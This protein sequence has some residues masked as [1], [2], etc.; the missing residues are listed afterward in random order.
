MK[1]Q[2]GVLLL[3]VG[4]KSYAGWAVN[5]AA[6]LHFYSPGLTIDIIV[7]SV[8]DAAIAGM[9]RSLFSRVVHIRPSDMHDSD[10]VFAPGKAKLSLYGYSRFEQTIYIDADSCVCRD[11]SPLF[12][13]LAGSPVKSQAL[14]FVT[15]KDTDWG[16]H[17]MP[18]GEA[19]QTYWLMGEYIL[20]VINSSFI[21]FEKCAEAERFFGM[22]KDN[23]IEGFK[24]KWGKS[25]PDELAFNIAAAQTGIDIRIG[26]GSTNFPVSF[27]DGFDGNTYILSLYAIS[28]KG[29]KRMYMQY[30]KIIHE[31]FNKIMKRSSNYDYRRMMR[32]KFIVRGSIGATQYVRQSYAV[33]N[34]ASPLPYLD[35][36]IGI[37]ITTRN[38]P[39]NYL[40]CIE[41]VRKFL[42]AGAELVVVDDASDVKYA[43]ATFTFLRNVG[44]AAAKNKCLELL[45]HCDHIFL[46]D[47]DCW[48]V[49]NGWERP[50]IESGAAH[51]S[52]TFDHVFPKVRN[53]NDMI[54]EDGTF[55]Y[56][57]N[58]CGC[59]LYFRGEAIK[60]AGGFARRF[61]KYGNEHVD[62][63]VRI[64][65]LGLTRHPFMDVKG[66]LSLFHSMDYFK[67]TAS[68]VPPGE[69]SK[70]WDIGTDISFHDYKI[71]ATEQL[72]V[73]CSY[74][75]YAVD[76]QRGVKW[77]ADVSKV[78]ELAKSVVDCGGRCVVFHDCF[79]NVPEI[80]G[81]DFV[82]VKCDENYV[83][84]VQR[85]LVYKQYLEDYWVPGD[86]FFVD[87]TDVVMLKAPKCDPG[88]LYIGDEEGVRLDNAW[89]RKEQE[90]FMVIPDYMEVF[91]RYRNYPLL[92]CGIIG[93]C[94]N[95]A[96]HY[97][98]VSSPYFRD[99]S[100][101]IM[102]STDMAA[103]N[104]VMRKHFNDCISHGYHVN[105]G[106]KKF[107]LNNKAWFQH[108]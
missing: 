56:Y 27:D 69:R 11:I 52:F 3:A 91:E 29:R 36:K 57:S 48:P 98:S 66:S 85:W 16:C 33:Q 60:T 9:E 99:Y 105:T 41:A 64:Y 26:L 6:S 84:T 47:D 22:A 54:E 50:Y 86:L 1:T 73:F 72:T 21:Y 53:G 44:I 107:E 12:D 76:G 5:L 37:G 46:F 28:A 83:T 10:G 81:I 93:G 4:N 23:F 70:N 2:K 82:R 13:E 65:K 100:R 97:I 77:D 45:D 19:R 17:W 101:G 95:I 96:E 89:I 108:K 14:S 75:N 87:S 59:M 63:S 88:L 43:D 58:P 94:A 30:R 102:T 104:Y 80:T 61:G 74:F 71:A 90:P 20:P 79:E 39:E 78:M 24:S 103:G 106:F 49:V 42:P 31:S 18:F 34:V 15:E 7:D 35:G 62:L 8:T 40:K 51:L 68:S 55:R 67:Q 92:N 38:R 32:N 25:F